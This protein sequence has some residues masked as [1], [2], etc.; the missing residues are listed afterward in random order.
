MA[1]VPIAA[2]I[3]DVPEPDRPTNEPTTDPPP[4]APSADPPAGA[5]GGQSRAA[6]ERADALLDAIDAGDT[7]AVD[8]L[9]ASDPSLATSRDPDGLSVVLHAC[10]RRHFA[11][12]ARL[13]EALAAAGRLDLLDAAALGR[14]ADVTAILDGDRGALEAWSP[15]GFSALHYA[16]YFGNAETARALLR[17][18]AD[19]RAPSR[20]P[21]G[22]LPH[23]SAASA[24]RGDVVQVLLDAGA[25]AD[26]TSH[27]GHTA[28]H[29]A[30][31]NG[32]LALV[33]LLLARD[34]IPG[35]PTD[36][37]RT[38]ADLAEAA[39]HETVAAVLRGVS[40]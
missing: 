40:K 8:G 24:G 29:S 25:P 23:H 19:A 38:A 17:E 16:A 9:L 39:G 32:D 18:G 35:R 21:M 37:G 3:P 5:S 15:D 36:D 2:G 14:A 28:L 30:A 12:A 27:G 22:V 11:M 6:S 33:Q 31:A 20:N 26:A 13:G 10:Y 7:A 4:D 34:V 1:I